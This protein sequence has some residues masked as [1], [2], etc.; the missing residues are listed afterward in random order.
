MSVELFVSEKLGVKFNIFKY[1]LWIYF[2][3]NA[4]FECTLVCGSIFQWENQIWLV[5]PIWLSSHLKCHSF[6]VISITFSNGQIDFSNIFFDIGRGRWP[7]WFGIILIWNNWCIFVRSANRLYVNIEKRHCNCLL[8]VNGLLHL[9]IEC[10]Q[11][12][13]LDFC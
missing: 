10:W 11:K 2:Q 8:S 5:P 13:I 7:N 3:I 12:M 4:M 9:T 6:C 1:F